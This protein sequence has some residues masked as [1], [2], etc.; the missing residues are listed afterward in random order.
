MMSTSE[1]SRPS[2]VVPT[3]RR[4]E[5]LR[6]CLDG[7][8]SQSIEP[9][10]MIVVRRA[11]DD[12]SEAVMAEWR[13]PALVDVV[14]DETG[15]LAAMEYGVRAA[16][17]KIIAFIDDDAVPRSDWLSRLVRHFDDPGV[18]GVGGRDVICRPGSGP[19]SRDAVYDHVLEHDVG[20]ITRWGKLIG[21]HHR[22]TGEAREVMVLKAAGMAF[23]RGAIAFPRGLRG[24]GAQVHFEVGM[25]LSALRRGWRL[26]YDPSAIVDHYVAT[27][28]DADQREAPA[29]SAVRDAAYNLTRCMIEEAPE[30]FWRRASYGLLLG[31][32]KTPG[33]LRASV[34]LARGERDV[35]AALSP[36]LSGQVAALRGRR[37][38]RPVAEGA[39]S[40]ADRRRPVAAERRSDTD[41][42][43]PVATGRRDGP[44]RRLA[45]EQRLVFVAHEVGGPGGMER[46]S[47]EL[48]SGLL[49]SGHEVTVVARSCHM[50]D[51]ARLR[52]ERIRTPRRPASIAYPAFFLAASLR[53]ATRYRGELLHTTGAIVFN[54]ADVSTVHYCHRAAA[55]RVEGSRASRP[56]TFYRLNSAVM[57]Q[58]A[59]AGEAYCYR[60]SKTRLLCAVSGGVASE[61]RQGFPDMAAAV[62]TVPNGVDS[63]RFAP[64]PEAR[65]SMRAELGLLPDTPV[66]TFVGGDWGRKGLD[67]AVDA[68][69]HAPGWHLLVAGTG[70]PEPI[71]TRARAAGTVDRIVFLGCV[72]DTP[73]LYAAADAFVLPTTYEAFPLVA[74]EA[75]AS[76]LPLLIT[77]VNGV[78][79]L[80]EDGVCG[81]FISRSADD[82]G[83]RLNALSRDPARAGAMGAAASAAAKA[84]DWEAMTAG[85]VAAYADVTRL[86]G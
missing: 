56:G 32:R 75:A 68:L 42:P 16:D 43:R 86:G 6:R 22:G 74:L 77:P 40:D 8:A 59:L 24:S 61:L 79:D 3:Y 57:R 36:S 29:R 76:G 58:L 5:A 2:V 48:I 15:V 39:R 23:R 33:L 19:A 20:R 65:M 83:A 27:R 62:R 13:H 52:V 21:N 78:T 80:L 4:P 51:D 67:F 26:I 17:A 9:A 60:P 82:I 55:G 81:W 46:V 28:F 66:A 64:N 1:L 25:S 37:R 63:T 11:G 34:G 10:Q 70:D 45:T 85:Y 35:V 53:L 14:V 73:R 72:S 71:L 84:F 54:R 18:G 12:G 44:E 7:L 49:E 41:R 31:D 50:P 69:T 30:L 47:E 38:P